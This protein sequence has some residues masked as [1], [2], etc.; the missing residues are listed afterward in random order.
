MKKEHYEKN[1]NTVIKLVYH[2]EFI[3]YVMVDVVKGKWIEKGKPD[4]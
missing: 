4:V 3:P 2:A 1:L